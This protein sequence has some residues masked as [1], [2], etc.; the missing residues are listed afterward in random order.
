MDV[1]PS[2]KMFE[3]M[4]AFTSALCGDEPHRMLVGPGANRIREQRRMTME[5]LH[6]FAG[7]A[8]REGAARSQNE[9]AH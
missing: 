1:T 3:A 2:P 9:K 4:Q 7:L 6:R 8:M 5:F